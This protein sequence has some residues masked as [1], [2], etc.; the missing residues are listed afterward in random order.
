MNTNITKYTI[1]TKELNY[2]LQEYI[3][4]ENIN[5]DKK[6]ME[7]IEQLN[8]IAKNENHLYSQWTLDELD[9]FL[10]EQD[11]IRN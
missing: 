1:I 6:F 3:Y 11:L 5:L 10:L 8:N 2:I 4:L 9:N 7:L